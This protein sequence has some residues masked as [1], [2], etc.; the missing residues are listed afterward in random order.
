VGA[1]LLGGVPLATYYSA[2]PASAGIGAMPESFADL[3]AK[4]TPAVVTISSMH[5]ME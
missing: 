5:V 4:V 1:L 3:A 2:P